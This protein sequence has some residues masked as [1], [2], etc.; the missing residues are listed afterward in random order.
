MQCMIVLAISLV[1]KRRERES[2][3]LSWLFVC[4]FIVST[5]NES[6]PTALPLKHSTPTNSLTEG[7]SFLL[8]FA[9]SILLKDRKIM[10]F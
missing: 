4:C 3:L 6:T 7:L 10:S 2:F 8:D 9:Q 1:A 5:G